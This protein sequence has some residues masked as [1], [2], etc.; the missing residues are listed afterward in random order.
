MDHQ[1]VFI[2]FP[3]KVRVVQ[4]IPGWVTPQINIRQLFDIPFN[5]RP[6]VSLL[7]DQ[8]I[9]KIDPS[10]L[11]AM[12]ASIHRCMVE[13]SQKGWNPVP[14]GKYFIPQFLV[15]ACPGGVVSKV[16]KMVTLFCRKLSAQISF[17]L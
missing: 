15:F 6:E 9:C 7:Q 13:L 5:M 14:S 17:P 4:K 3:R 11:L 12:P 16:H 2:S 8:N 1:N 10:F